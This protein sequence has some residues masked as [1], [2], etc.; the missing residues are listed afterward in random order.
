MTNSAWLLK[1]LALVLLL[2]MPG[3]RESYTIVT[4]LFADGSCDRVIT[5]SS[6][7]MRIPSVAFPLPIDSTWETS[8]KA[9]T[10][11]GEKYLFTARKRFAHID[12]LRQEYSRINDSS[13]IRISVNVEESFRWFYTYFTYTEKY[14]AFNPLGQIPLSEF[15]TADEIQ[16]FLAGER[17]DSLKKKRDA[18]EMRNMFE[19]YYQGLLDA[20]GKLHHR[21]LPASLIEA[22][23]EELYAEL[24]SSNSN[25]VVKVTTAVLRT[26]AVRKLSREIRA[27]ED[28]IMR[29]S[30]LAARAD[31]DYVS[32]VVM[33]GTILD[34]NA[35]EVKGNSVVWR[36]SDEQLG[37]A[38]YEMRVE[39]R[40][41]NIW[42]LAVTGLV[43][44]ALI[45]LPTTLR[46][47]RE[48]HLV[49]T[50]A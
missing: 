47:R 9:P 13:K 7:S 2:T 48:R 36:F 10:Q 43:V 16:R 44:L 34:T 8:W 17:S 3:C 19:V 21:A 29:R 27:L 40:R 1:S 22:K 50:R 5:V 23:K 12:S 42:P 26:S 25:D 4:T 38:D 24:M 49:A 14:E 45:L 46:M 18:W 28:E 20:A 11:K 37:I 15:M 35:G 30:E 32:T 33:P 41:V 31:G 6:D 39:S